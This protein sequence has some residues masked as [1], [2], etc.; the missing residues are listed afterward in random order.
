MIE[1]PCVVPFPVDKDGNGP[2][3]DEVAAKTLWQVWDECFVTLAEFDN[4]N[5]AHAWVQEF[6]GRKHHDEIM[7]FR[8]TLAREMRMDVEK[9]RE[10][11]MFGPKKE[12][13][14]PEKAMS[15]R[16]KAWDSI[17]GLFKKT[18]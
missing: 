8:E 2:C 10:F 12:P 1:F 9:M 16:Q 4:Q 11:I 7:A 13:T 14:P 17:V 3:S 18:K 6:L 5:E 15:F